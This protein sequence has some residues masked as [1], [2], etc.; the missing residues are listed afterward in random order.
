MLKTHLSFSIAHCHKF[1][2]LD[3]KLI[4]QSAI[5]S[6]KEKKKGRVQLL[7]TLFPL[8]IEQRKGA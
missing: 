1:K 3:L 5:N 6:E 7:A 8:V 4:D 2:F